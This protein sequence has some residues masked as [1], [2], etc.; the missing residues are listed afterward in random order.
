MATWDLDGTKHHLFIC[1]GGCCMLKYGEE[2]TMAIRD[3]IAI[4]GA[5]SLIHT[6]RTRCNGR[7][8]DACVVIHYPEGIWYRDVT[9][10]IGRTIVKELIRSGR[11]LQDQLTYVYQSGF[12][13]AGGSAKGKAKPS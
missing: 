13:A 4:H 5:D 8:D 11:P 7:C 9:P 2:V 12:Q 10:E 6:T 1:N 3:E